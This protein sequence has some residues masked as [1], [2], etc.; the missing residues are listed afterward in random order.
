[1]IYARYYDPL[2]KCHEKQETTLLVSHFE[3][4][5]PR[6]DQCAFGGSRCGKAILD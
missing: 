5:I 3:A 2:A 6:S 4:S 1:M